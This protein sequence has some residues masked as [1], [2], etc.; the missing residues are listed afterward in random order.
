MHAP[1]ISR[2]TLLKAAGVSLALPLLDSML[3]RR[4][5]AG[6]AD[7]RHRVVCINTSL[8]LHGENFFPAEGGRDYQPSTYLKLLEEFRNDLTVFSGVS[9]PDV[10]GGHSAELSYLTAA[11]H[12]G[13]PS[14]K[15]S[16]SFDQLI[17]ERLGAETRYASLV[18]RTGGAGI[19]FTRGGVM[20]PAEDRPSKLFARLFLDGGAKEV[21][22]QIERLQDGQS[23]LDR[24]NDRA[25]Q[26]ERTLGERDRQKLDE[27][28]SSVRE[29][30]LRLQAAEAWSKRPKPRVDARPPLDIS[31]NA[32]LIGKTRLMYDMVH[33]ALS[34]D[35]TRVI[36]LNIQGA[37]QTP[38]IEGVTMDHHNLSHH[39]KD[40]TKLEQLTIVETAEFNA[41]AELLK[42]LKQTN[43]QG[44]SLLARTM[45]MYGSNL[46]N[47]S[48]HD[49]K[50]MPI[51]LAG[52]GFRH[53]Q[54]LAF[55][56][57]KNEPLANLFVSMIQRMGLE[58]DRFGSSTGTMKGLG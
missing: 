10:D 15:N 4:A 57:E 22:Q 21:E 36:T 19:S 31:G 27:Y 50:N 37:N 29:L 42:K 45:V 40:P 7:E 39:G 53:G 54:H 52:G 44:D 8:G 5:R 17:A 14:F 58:I 2:R 6:Q 48:S 43:E 35:S 26:L 30:E 33:L 9:H 46:G 56:R 23:I 28:F 20:V 12:P 24:V 1:R 38:P 25:K 47:A 11:P 13:S 3:P 41:L 51:L 49:T 32:D 16:V 18:L 34:T 55:S